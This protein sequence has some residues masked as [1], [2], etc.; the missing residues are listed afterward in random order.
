MGPLHDESI[1]WLLLAKPRADLANINKDLEQ[2]CQFPK[3][4]A[5]VKNLKLSKVV[6][7]L[8]RLP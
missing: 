5:I 3:E 8:P 7:H 1:E 2:C 4:E 6:A